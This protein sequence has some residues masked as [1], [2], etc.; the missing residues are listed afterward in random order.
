MDKKALGLYIHIPFCKR[1]CLYCDFPSYAGMEDYWDEYTSA[2]IDELYLRSEEFKGC[3]IKTI[4]I[5]GGTPSILPHSHIERILDAVY[6]KFSVKNS[7]ESTIEANPG[8]LTPEKLKAYKGVG[9]NRLSMGLQACQDE[10]LKKLG[11]V[12]NFRDFETAVKLAQDAGFDNMNADII[13]GIPG[14]SFRDW[15]ETVSRVLSFDLTHISCYSLIIE[16]G[17]PFYRMREE[18]SLIPIDDDLDRQMYHHAV[19]RFSDAG[20]T[21]YEISNFSKPHYQCQHNMNYWERGEYIGAGAGAHSF[22]KNRR[23]ANTS[24]V[25]K[26]IEGIRNKKPVLAEDSYIMPE[27]ALAEKMFLGLRMNKGVNIKEVSGEFG[28]DAGEKYRKSLE[29]LLKNGLIEM[30][31]GFVKLTD[32]GMDLANLVFVEFI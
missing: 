10:I 18:G 12:H 8:T 19:N 23:Y 7:C 5:G 25:L 29:K 32:K 21:Q 24:D 17:T 11:R 20:F 27:D 2:L 14:Q 28:I 3:T 6:S 30:E 26:Y 13:F 15:D 16:E 1:K 31:N 9:I 4:F 22:F